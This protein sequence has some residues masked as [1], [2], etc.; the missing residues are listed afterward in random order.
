MPSPARAVRANR[1]FLPCPLMHTA[2]E[3]ARGY[4]TYTLN[5]LYLR[6]RESLPG[7]GHGGGLAVIEPTMLARI[8]A[9]ADSEAK[10]EDVV[11]VDIHA[12]TVI[13]ALLVICT[14]DTVP[15]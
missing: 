4:C 6:R 7:G 8:L 2:T 14:I 1:P 3:L 13:A 15:Q 11:V 12:L 10:A 9:E 5:P